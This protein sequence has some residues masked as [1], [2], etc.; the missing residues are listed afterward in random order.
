MDDHIWPC[1]LENWQQRLHVRDISIV[2]IYAG[3]AICGGS[4]IEYGCFAGIGVHQK[5][6]DVVA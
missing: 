4:D 1:L 6:D 2:V 5:V 3:A